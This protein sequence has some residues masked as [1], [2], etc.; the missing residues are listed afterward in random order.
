MPT[1]QI[2]SDLHIEYKNDITPDPLT[3]ITPVADVLILAGDIGSLY[4]LE[5][6]NKFLDRLCPHFDVVLYIPGNHEYYSIEGYPPVTMAVLSQRLKHLQNSISNLYILNKDCVTIGNVCIAG[7]T[8]WSEP[9]VKIPRYIVRLENTSDE[10]YKSMFNTDVQFIKDSVK[11]AKQNKL[12]LIVVTHHC[13]TYRVLEGTTKRDKFSSLYASALDHMLSKEDIETW[14][15]GHTHENFDFVTVDGTRVV[16]NQK[17]KPKDR[18][19]NFS[20][21]F[22]INI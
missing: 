20:K 3:M 21:Q 10:K 18:V 17:G 16:G 19:N 5:Q 11:Y 13:P 6:L 9:T 12:R 22:T 2:A 7:C 8:L 4:K 14:I 15:C 1:L